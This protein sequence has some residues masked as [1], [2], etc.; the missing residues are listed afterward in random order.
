MAS[1]QSLLD[2]LDRADRADLETQAAERGLSAEE[3]ALSILR[4]RIKYARCAAV[5]LR[6]PVVSSVSSILRKHYIEAE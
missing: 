1:Q 2:E 3:Y 5:G 4:E 6:A